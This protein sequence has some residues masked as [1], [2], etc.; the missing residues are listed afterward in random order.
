MTKLTSIIFIFITVCV[1]DYFLIKPAVNWGGDIIEYYGITESLINHGSPK[2]TSQDKSNITKLLNPAYFEDPQ[3]Y[4]KNSSGD[5]Y[6]VHF[7]FYSILLIPMRVLLEIFGQ[8]PIKTIALTNL[9]ILSLTVLFIIKKFIT[10]T[11]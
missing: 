3:Y 11:T 4:I 8:N 6:P 10:G 7:I 5:R 9:I 1:L 2:L